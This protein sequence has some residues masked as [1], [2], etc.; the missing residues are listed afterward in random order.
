MQRPLVSKF[1]C[2]LEAAASP[3]FFSNP[4]HSD[5]CQREEGEQ[6]DES[7]LDLLRATFTT[8]VIS[9]AS[10]LLSKPS[11]LLVASFRRNKDPKTHPKASLLVPTESRGDSNHY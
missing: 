1:L 7:C 3:F 11:H 10:S 9:A 4:Q 2:Y 6:R 8:L 5:E